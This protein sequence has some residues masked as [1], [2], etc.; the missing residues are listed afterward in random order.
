MTHRKKK[1][2]SIKVKH[3]DKLKTH[4]KGS[5]STLLND[6]S[7]IIWFWYSCWKIKLTRILIKWK[8]IS[9]YKIWTMW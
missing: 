8:K 9:C 7:L 2:R 5:E 6:G 3:Y 4:D 1:L